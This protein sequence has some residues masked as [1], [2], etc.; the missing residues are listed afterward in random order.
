MDLFAVVSVKGLSRSRLNLV[1]GTLTVSNIESRC[2][3]LT[4]TRT[5]SP[6]NDRPVT[7]RKSRTEPLNLALLC[8]HRD[9][10]CGAKR[11]CLNRF[12]RLI[13]AAGH[14]TGTIANK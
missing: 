8:E 4:K 9:P 7:A 3:P 14:E 13:A 6:G 2:N 10:V 11:Q 1:A 5:F 12:G